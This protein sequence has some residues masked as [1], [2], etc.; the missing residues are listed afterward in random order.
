MDTV[1][2]GHRVH[3]TARERRR[4]QARIVLTIEK[5]WKGSFLSMQR[6]H[7]GREGEPTM[8]KGWYCKE[9]HKGYLYVTEAGES[10]F[11]PTGAVKE[12][13]SNQRINHEREE[14]LRAK[15][16]SLYVSRSSPP[17]SCPSST[18]Q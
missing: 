12:T 8:E 3:G 17:D 10:G 6:R 18:A 14:D 5:K 2:P 11:R 7:H 13:E 1:R 9:Q 4:D 15:A 16:R